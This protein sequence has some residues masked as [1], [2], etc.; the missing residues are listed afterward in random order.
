[1]TELYSHVSLQKDLTFPLNGCHRGCLI[2]PE[3]TSSHLKYEIITWRFKR[4]S[5]KAH[6]HIRHIK[7]DKTFYCGRFKMPKYIFSMHAFK[8]SQ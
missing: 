2:F 6:S 3:H 7:Q 5:E 8:A 1:M 4:T